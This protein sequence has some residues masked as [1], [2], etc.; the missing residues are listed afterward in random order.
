MRKDVLIYVNPTNG[1]ITK[2]QSIVGMSGENLQGRIIFTFPYGKFIDGVAWLEFERGTEKGYL[3]MNKVENT[4]QLEIL[5]SLLNI[6]HSVLVIFGLVL[7]NVH[8]ICY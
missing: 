1:F 3:L 7:A 4:Y 5:S 6:F 8:L 2:D